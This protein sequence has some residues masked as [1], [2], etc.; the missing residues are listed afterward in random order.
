M[1]DVL[2][3]GRPHE[4]IPGLV[5][6]ARRVDDRIGDRRRELVTD[7]ERQVRLRQEPRLEDASAILVRDAALPTVTDRF[8]HRH[9]DVSRFV[10][11]RVDHRLDA[12][13][14]DDCLDFD[15]VISFERRSRN[16]VSRHTPSRFATRSR[17]PTMRKPHFWCN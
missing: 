3:A 14:Y 16:T 17:T 12:L 9:A 8:D 1:R 10:L 7:D 13:A 15:H 4:A 11:D 5:A 2:D 6:A